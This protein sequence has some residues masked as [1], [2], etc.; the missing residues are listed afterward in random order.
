MIDISKLIDVF[1]GEE[2]LKLAAVPGGFFY[3]DEEKAPGL[4]SGILGGLW[5]ADIVIARHEVFTPDLFSAFQKKYAEKYSEE[6]PGFTGD[7]VPKDG[8]AG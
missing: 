2:F 1:L 4:K 6:N 5:R 3:Y 7:L 8:A